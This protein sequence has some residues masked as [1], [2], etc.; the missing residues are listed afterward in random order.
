MTNIIEEYITELTRVIGDIHV[1]IS[2]SIGTEKTPGTALFSLAQME[3]LALKQLPAFGILSTS[4]AGFLV[5]PSNS[6]TVHVSAG[7]VG[8]NSRQ[9]SIAPQDV[10]IFRS[11]ASSYSASSQYGVS[12]GIPLSEVQKATQV[13]Q[14]AVTVSSSATDNKIIID[15]ISLAQS[16]GLPLK[17]QVGSSFLIFSQIDVANSALI[18]DSNYGNGTVQTDH[19]VGEFVY[20]IYEPHVK[21][22]VGLPVDIAWQSGNDPA[23]F[24]YY[25]PMPSDWLPIAN[26]LVSNPANPLVVCVTKDGSGNCS[27]YA[28][29][30]TVTE[31]PVP[32]DINPIFNKADS[33][34]IIAASRQLR[35]TL[36]QTYPL[37]TVGDLIR[38][39]EQYTIAINSGTQTGFSNYWSKRPFSATTY[40]GRGVSFDNLER[41]EFSDNFIKSYY[42]TVGADLQHTFGIFRGDLYDRQVSSTGIP[43]IGVQNSV[44]FPSSYAPSTLTNGTY[45]YE[46]TAVTALGESIASSVALSSSNFLNSST[47]LSEIQWNNVPN[48]LFYHIYRRAVIAGDQSEYRI[49]NPGDITGLGLPQPSGISINTDIALTDPYQSFKF[50]AQD[51]S[52]LGSNVN[53]IGGVAIKLK[54][55]APL[56]QPTLATDMINVDIYS[57]QNGTPGT[58]LA[59]GSPIM[60]KNITN[61]YQTFISQFDLA[62][63]KNTSYWIVLHKTDVTTGGNIVLGAGNSGQS[64][65]ATSPDKQSWSVQSSVSVW[66]YLYSYLD[67]NRVGV[68]LTSRGIKLTGKKSLIPR[69]LSV[70]VPPVNSDGITGYIPNSQFSTNG[71]ENTITQN[72]MIVTVTARLGENG[73]PSQ[74][75]QIV[76]QGTARD[77]R[78][79]L[80]D[81]TQLFDRIDDMQVTPGANL[82]LGSSNAIQ[83]SVYDLVTVETVP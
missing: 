68:K 11:F 42:D 64:L 24:S 9:I 58:L 45:V 13:Y 10:T 62:A 74:F 22:L 77:T 50:V 38:S 75:V 14:S 21:S 51:N 27:Q 76:P 80:G 7:K 47:F 56:N 65:Y 6:K 26:I 49:T 69:R 19:S 67:N 31:W 30:R 83:W 2:S 17:A 29:E 78:F 63:T 18:V 32:S 28:I 5:T 73:V 20:F 79:T 54:I 61:L 52:L 23:T 71:V 40:F 15:N 8:Y 55:S 72:D 12:I 37:I 41:M 53:Q 39:F 66:F 34:I 70:Y 82:T 59:T 33:N 35:S 3:S 46:V 44:I 43:P 1:K 48:V 81:T 25:H 36:K 16:L 57:D 4:P 60:M